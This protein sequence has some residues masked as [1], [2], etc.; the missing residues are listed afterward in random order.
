MVTRYAGKAYSEKV[1]K[2]ATARLEAAPNTP[3]MKGQ[4][5]SVSGCTHNLVRVGIDAKAS[6]A[7]G[8]MMATL[9]SFVNHYKIRASPDSAPLT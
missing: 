5:D 9:G 4:T 1:H 3:I 7:I 6:L 2:V 8:K